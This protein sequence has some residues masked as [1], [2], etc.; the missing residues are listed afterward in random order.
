MC[1]NCFLFLYYDDLYRCEKVAW[2]IE[3]VPKMPKVPKV[4]K[5]EEL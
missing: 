5:I 2:G 1:F 4:P 3:E